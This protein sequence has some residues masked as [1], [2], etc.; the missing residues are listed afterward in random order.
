MHSQQPHQ[1]SSRASSVLGAPL[2]SLDRSALES[3]WD[4]VEALSH[5]ELLACRSSE[6]SCVELLLGPA[7]H[8]RLVAAHR[9]KNAYDLLA[10]AALFEVAEPGVLRR[11]CEA[12]Q[13]ELD[14]RST[15]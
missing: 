3:A 6:N 14:A 2:S 10:Q 7:E 5:A 1:P 4:E 8:G 13:R 15:R 9:A 12:A 11:V